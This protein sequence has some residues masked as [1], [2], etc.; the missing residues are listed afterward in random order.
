MHFMLITGSIQLLII[1]LFYNSKSSF[2]LHWIFFCWVKTKSFGIVDL[3][4]IIAL[5]S[6]SC[7]NDIAHA[8]SQAVE[9]GCKPSAGR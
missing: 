7:C 6:L 8:E 2:S 5:V 1:K 9:R 3:V 4:V